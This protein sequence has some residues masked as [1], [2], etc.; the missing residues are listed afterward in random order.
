[1]T[2]Q[3]TGQPVGEAQHGAVFVMPRRKIEWAGSAALWV[4]AA[5]WAA[6]TRSRVGHAWIV[7]PDGVLTPEAAIRFGAREVEGRRRKTPVPLPEFV[8]TGVKDILRAHAAHSYRDV[9]EARDWSGIQLE[10]VWQH[11]DLFHTA[12]EPLARRHKCPLVS[13]VHAPQVWE[14]RRW[15]VLRPGWGSLLERTAERPQLVSSD[16]VACVS[17]EVANELVRFGIDERRLLVSP[18]AIDANRFGPAVSGERV[19][20]RFGL[21]DRFVV[22][23]TGTF[24]RFHALE[25]AVEAFAIVHRHADNARLLLVGD[26]IERQRIEQLAASLG[27]GE[28]VV[29]TGE[30]SPEDLPEYIATMDAVFVT[31]RAG[32]DFHYSPLKMREYHASACA[33]VA[34]RIGEA[35]R[36]LRDGIDALVYEPGDA[37]GL[38]ERLLVLH[39]NPALRA[40][41]G[42]AGRKVV[43]ATGTWDV[44]LEQLLSSL[45]YREA[46]TRLHQ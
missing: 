42:S 6:A 18:M 10:F 41:I 8:S 45:P 21:A 28:F 11:H 44:R 22:G 32:Q 2:H 43:L 33:L 23:W 7:A 34:P 26:G 46:V 30:V 9:G 13:F 1:M 4:T 5:G 24:R 17:N 40:R 29:F 3:S 36:S 27:L 20:H 19:R 31:A 37:R 16:V 14:A 39:N 15:G 12:G 38:A 35:A 25:L